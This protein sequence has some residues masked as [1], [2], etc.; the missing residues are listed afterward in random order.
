MEY[1]VLGCHSIDNHGHIA[2]NPAKVIINFNSAVI[3]HIRLGVVN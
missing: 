1:I 3:S 2:Q